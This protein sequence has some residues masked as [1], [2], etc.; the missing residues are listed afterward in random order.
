MTQSFDGLPVSSFAQCLCMRFGFG[1]RSSLGLSTL[2][3]TFA[4]PRLGAFLGFLATRTAET[5]TEK[6]TS[7]A[8][9]ET[10]I[11][12]AARTIGASWP[13]IWRRLIRFISNINGWKL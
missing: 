1:L 6:A 10:N 7:T 12:V 9:T 3:G 4:L 5:A 13:T 8:R 2:P 11:P